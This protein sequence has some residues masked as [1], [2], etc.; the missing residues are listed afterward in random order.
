MVNVYHAFEII[1]LK[2]PT[3][4]C[5]DQFSFEIV[6]RFVYVPCGDSRMV[7]RKISRLV[8]IPLLL[9]KLVTL[10][11][12]CMFAGTNRESSRTIGG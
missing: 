12:N 8:E 5:F 1:S 6:G 7:K 11:I 9:R 4:N 3:L 10:K 2:D